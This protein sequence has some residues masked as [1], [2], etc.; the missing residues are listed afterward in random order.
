MN[1]VA[2]RSHRVAAAVIVWAA[3]TIVKIVCGPYFL[4]IGLCEWV[5]ERIKRKAG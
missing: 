3:K 1:T 2:H 5:G 4:F